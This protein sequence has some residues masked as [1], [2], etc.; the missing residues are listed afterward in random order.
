MSWRFMEVETPTTSPENAGPNVVTRVGNDAHNND[1]THSGME[2]EATVLKEI[3]QG[4]GMRLQQA[5]PGKSCAGRREG[6]TARRSTELPVSSADP[7]LA[8]PSADSSRLSKNRYLVHKPV[9]TTAETVSSSPQYNS[10]TLLSCEGLNSSVAATI[11]HTTLNL[12]REL[13]PFVFLA[14]LSTVPAALS[15]L[16]RHCLEHK[17]R[18]QVS[19]LLGNKLWSTLPISQGGV[20]KRWPTRG[21]LFCLYPRTRWKTFFLYLVSFAWKVTK[22]CAR[23]SQYDRGLTV[24]V[25]LIVVFATPVCACTTTSFGSALE[26]NDSFDERCPIILP[27]EVISD[28]YQVILYDLYEYWKNIVFHLIVPD[29]EEPNRHAWFDAKLG[30]IDNRVLTETA[31]TSSEAKGGAQDLKWYRPHYTDRDKNEVQV[32]QR[33]VSHFHRFCPSESSEGVSEP[34]LCAKG[35]EDLIQYVLVYLGAESPA[36][37]RVNKVVKITWLAAEGCTNAIVCW[38][39]AALWNKPVQLVILTS[40]DYIREAQIFATRVHA[41]VLV[42]KH[43][44]AGGTSPHIDVKKSTPTGQPTGKT[45]LHDQ[46]IKDICDMNSSGEF[47][48]SFTT[49]LIQPCSSAWAHGPEGWH[50]RQTMRI[51][52]IL[53][54]LISE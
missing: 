31:A 28:E 48:I 32:I 16:L 50:G 24:I 10:S 15:H 44:A 5:V 49:C 46:V 2:Q 34:F 42:M 18:T 9:S 17:E 39:I 23:L 4:D 38:A 30:N 14:I 22:Y 6:A 12:A 8:V 13:C 7:E 51:V 11:F 29:E 52:F 37:G 19:N 47:G 53:L 54:V 20:T 45:F 3:S 33:L 36:E 25:G 21:S 43:D 40:A 41:A 35:F 26:P 27:R 1:Q